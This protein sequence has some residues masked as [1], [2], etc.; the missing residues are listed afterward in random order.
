MKACAMF[1]LTLAAAVNP[2]A[3]G[4]A[5]TDRVGIIGAGPAGIHLAAELQRLGFNSVTLLERTARVGGKSLTIYR[6]V[7]DGAPCE[8]A[9][10]AATGLVDTET[11][12][13]FEMGTCFLHNGC[14]CCAREHRYLPKDYAI[15]LRCSAAPELPSI[16]SDSTRLV[17]DCP[18]TMQSATS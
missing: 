14:K 18:Q 15:L 11:C 6:N 9:V 4:P 8:Q 7:D 16:R 12:V 5:N 17:Y 1:A 3:A 2:A 10:D 13:A